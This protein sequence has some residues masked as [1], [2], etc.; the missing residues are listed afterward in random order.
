MSAA[1][2]ESKTF[3]ITHRQRD[4]HGD[5]Q[6]DTETHMEIPTERHTWRYTQRD[7]ETHT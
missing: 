4:T 1:L 7:T 3:L 5:T 6:R 2:S